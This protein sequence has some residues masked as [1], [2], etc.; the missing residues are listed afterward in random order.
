[1]K[2]SLPGN[3]LKSLS[4]AEVRRLT[5]RVQ[6]SR[7]LPVVLLLLLACVHSQVATSSLRGV[8]SDPS[9]AVIAGVTVVLERKDV[10]FHAR[11]QTD[12][13]GT[14]QFQQVPPGTYALTLTSAGFAEQQGNV[15]LLVDQPAT[16]NVSLQVNSTTTT[17]DVDSAMPVLN[18]TD[19]SI[20]NAVENASVQAL[21]MEGRNVPDLLSLQ[22][23][24]LYLGHN[25]NQD[26]DSR[27]GSVAGARSD[28]GNVT[29]DG[30]DNN[31]QVHGY[32]FTGVLRSTLDSVDEFRVSTTNSGVDSGRSSG[33]QVNVVSRS[34]TNSIHGSVY[35]YNRNT[36]T[37]ANNWFN[38]EAE[39]AEGRP[40]RPGELIRNTFGAA[41]GGPIKKDKMFFFLNYEAQRTAENQ[42]VTQIVPT[43]SFRAGSL[44][45]PYINS[46][47]GQS[48][49]TLTP[50]DFAKLDPHCSGLGTCPWGAGDDPNI[51][52]VFNSY[53]MPNG[54]LAGDGYNTNS[55]SWSAPNPTRL[56]TYIGKI[57][58]AISDRHRMFV[59][60]N[61]QNDHRSD[62]PP[63]PGG[64]PINTYTSNTKGIGVG[65]IW[66]IS[67]S[68]V[69][70]ARYGFIRQGYSNRGSG[71]GPYVTLAS[72]SNPVGETRTSLFKVPGHNFI[73][74]LTWTK[75]KHT[76]QFGANYRIVHAITDTDAYSYNTAASS[77]GEY[78][79]SIANTGQDLDPSGFP[80]LGFPSVAPGFDN[81]YS[82]AAMNLAGVIAAVNL[83]Y[84]Y[85]V[86]QGSGSLLPQGAL[87]DRNFK[88]N[89]FEYYVQ[90]TFRVRPNLSLTF[91]VRHS[92]AQTPYEVNGQQVQQDVSVN[93]W[94][95]TR[96]TQAA[97]GNSV[98]PN[99]NYVL[100]G[101]ANHGKP[102]WPM[103][104]LNFAPRVGIAYAFDQK[105]S[106]RAGFGMD[107]D[108][109]GMAV[110]NIVS[111]GG[112]AGL[113]GSNATPAGWVAP[114]AAPRFT[115]LQNIP[116]N[117]SILTQPTSTVGFPYQP[118][119]GAEGFVF[120]VD[121]GVK[122][123]YSYQMDFSV[124]RELPGG[125]T[126]E[127]AYVGRLGRRLLQNRD[128]GMPLNLVDRKSGMDYFHAA[129]LI[130][131]MA[132]NSVPTTSVKPIPYW[133]NLFPDAA[134]S[135]ASGV[136]TP[137][138]S[139]T[140]NIYDHFRTDLLN[141]SYAIYDMDVL[142]S[143]G[144]GGVTNRYYPSQY[145]DLFT[146]SSIG[147]SSYHS[148]QI[149][150]RHPMRHGLQA[151]FNYTFG[152]SI[153]LGSDSE[154][155]GG[156]FNTV[157]NTTFNSFSQII[158]VFNPKL[159]RAVSDF[160][161]R[162]LITLDWVYQLP[163][164]HSQQF[165]G[166]AHG[167]LNAVIGGWQLSGLGRWTGGLPF[168][169]QVAAGWVTAWSYQ[170]F[171]V[172]TGN[173]KIHKHY[174]PGQGPQ[175]FADPNALEANILSGSPLRYPI[176]GEA[177]TRNA[178]R[179]DGFFGI[180]GGLSKKWEVR[181]RMNLNFSWE[182]FN[183]TNA[184]RFDT[185]PNYS[186]QSQFNAGN[187]GFYSA[188]LTQPRIQQFSLRLS[189]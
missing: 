31:D 77:F 128:L 149:I 20:G 175:V 53:P 84:V 125:F 7:L 156:V 147:T 100:S 88:S 118:P 177:G 171:L 46:S 143:P 172:S 159:N 6:L 151:D 153:D 170:S 135:G 21:P 8:V 67:P 168:G 109:F 69:N 23:G 13:N 15:Q 184:V 134:G 92:L 90:D 142:C 17:V 83:N 87:V 1:M 146:Q 124:Q 111:T 42:Q 185:N 165:L 29:L 108:N 91:G 174:V 33:A 178:F 155:L 114:G 106:I 157:S 19:A 164:G 95:D 141:A 110:A 55:F 188:T 129:D 102:M 44:T 11:R 101:K 154:R 14:Y 137:G 179:G 68:V 65:E 140:Q 5:T 27:S 37:A 112:S 161:T 133:E 39:L 76:L 167:F 81:S 117:L 113:L 152:K 123:P 89:Q 54:S 99:F 34:G 9:G 132:Y 28:Q 61:L 58:Y 122:T 57:D 12:A 62:P 43:A 35:E 104:N 78:F 79:D 162:H 158:N 126:V 80:Q 24:V 72:V 60:G 70:N 131:T 173:V 120:T 64:A 59:R 130:E 47:S 3:V 136:G 144:C 96:V 73:D 16:R 82:Y 105:T 45:Y 75:G 50:S 93:K 107:Y 85:K 25:V 187:F 115:G 52:A 148:G 71:S 160:D 36:F 51:L 10:G 150:V 166:G 26:Q 32:A 139:A 22:P 169:S 48:V 56:A 183:V 181:E 163:F 38:K 98:Q 180:D 49:F 40:N 176:P 116:T 4:N 182:V 66:T 18:T 2:N 30:L 86:S 103:A 74:D 186:L 127:L 138:Y 63:L 97:L 94:F 121:D 41:V 189:F 145:S 119:L